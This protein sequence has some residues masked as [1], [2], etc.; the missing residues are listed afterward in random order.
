MK[1]LKHFIRKDKYTRNDI[2]TDSNSRAQ[3]SGIPPNLWSEYTICEHCGS[4]VNKQN[5]C[6]VCGS[7]MGDMG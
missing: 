6:P 7:Y 5:Y 1:Q 4:L 3:L 2:Y